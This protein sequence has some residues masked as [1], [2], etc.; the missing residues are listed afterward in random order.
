MY[1]QQMNERKSRCAIAIVA[2]CVGGFASLADPAVARDVV[3]TGSV[4]FYLDTSAFRGRE[5]RV[6]ESVAVRIPNSE[7][8]FEE[9]HGRLRSKVRV[10]VRIADLEGKEIISDTRDME[11]FEE[12]K[13]RSASPLFFQTIIKRYHIDAGSYELSYA[14]ED[15]L[16]REVSI[17]GIVKG[18]NKT[19]AV[20]R[21]R[22]D[23]PEIYRETA[24][25]SEALF[26]WSVDQT[27][28]GTEYHPNPPRVYGLYKDTLLVYF[29]LYLPDEMARAQSFEFVT[30][31]A[32]MSGE[33]VK[34]TALSLPNPRPLLAGEDEASRTYPIVIR[35]DLTEI[36]AGSYSLYVRFRLGGKTMSR[37][38]SG[39]FS[40]AW[41][42]RTWELPRREYLA[43]ARF[44]LGDREFDEFATLGLGEQ[45]A[46]ITKL[47][48]SYDPSPETEANEAHDMFLVRLAYA[49]SHYA[50]HEA[51]VFSPRG[52][53][54]LRYGPPDDFIEDVIPLNRETLREA[55]EI[56]EDPYHPMNFTSSTLK[57][58][59]LTATKNVLIDPRNISQARPGDNQGYPYELWIYHG[60]G[61][62]LLERD[63]TSEMDVG[64][65]YLFTDREGFGRYKLE[66]SSTI[67]NK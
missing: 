10:F 23:L 39:K 31:I 19:G 61:N 29:E 30:E 62:P 66:T 25:F 28:H 51:A 11:F 27:E 5:G 65:R 40:V 41:D 32:N 42:L 53:I 15:L 3:S 26:A 20:R 49:N 56:V 60:M 59:G 47:W 43:E 37:V 67:S 54:Y 34:S 24:S 64:M 33:V 1:G 21:Y 55:M 2:M 8:R 58:Y 17:S 18:K 16:A 57:T 52:Q 44:L 35:E 7:L 48:Q 6:L 22:L 46:T 38:R 4:L 12:T 45:E 9:A 36:T 63:R 50:D 13:R 14:I